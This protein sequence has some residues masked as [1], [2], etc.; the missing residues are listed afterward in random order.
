MLIHAA[1]TSES[2][3]SI[4]EEHP[5]SKPVGILKKHPRGKTLVSPLETEDRD[6]KESVEGSV[7]RDVE[8]PKS[9]GSVSAGPLKK[10][11]K[12]TSQD[13]KPH[14]DMFLKQLH[15]LLTNINKYALLS[16]TMEWMPH[17]KSFRILRWDVLVEQILPRYFSDLK[18]KDCDG[19]INKFRGIL[20]EL[21]FEEVKRGKDYGCWFHEVSEC[22][23]LAN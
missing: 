10:R 12:I 17:G 15:T 7:E 5:P 14:G 22:V 8:S 4:D 11:R 2:L 3:N 6:G 13:D 1:A 21:G 20:I 19:L 23:D 16:E 9:D 18:E